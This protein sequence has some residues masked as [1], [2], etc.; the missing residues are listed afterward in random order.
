MSKTSHRSRAYAIFALFLED[1]KGDPRGVKRKAD[2]HKANYERGRSDFSK[3]SDQELGSV[4]K[5]QPSRL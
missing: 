5:R 2:C 3:D 4:V 1:A